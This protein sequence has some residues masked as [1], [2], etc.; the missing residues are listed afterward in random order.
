MLLPALPLKKRSPATTPFMQFRTILLTALLC[1]ATLALAEKK[2]GTPI[3]PLYLL[4]EPEK[5]LSIPQPDHP[6]QP[7][8][9]LRPVVIHTD[10]PQQ[11]IDV[12]HYQGRINWEIVA[13]NKDIR[14]VYVKATEGSGYVDDYYLRN[15][16]GAKQAGIPVGVYHFYRPTASVLTQLENFRD[17]VDPRQ[18]DLIPIV[19]VEKRGR[20]SLVHFQR[21]LLAFLEGV[22]RMF[23][24]KPIIY[25]GVNFYAKYLRGKF[26]QYRFMV[27]RYA[28]EFPGLCE[29]VPILIWQYSCTGEVD[30]IEGDVDRSVFLDRYS[31]ADIM[32]PPLKKGRK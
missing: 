27:A 30:G 8:A 31:V 28:E 23:G 9:E 24:V 32:L 17:N 16:Y 21:S 1:V 10:V 4:P 26:T 12:S 19:D 7:V 22:E 25:T 6:L 3:S 2:D 5:P 20:G 11:G 13:H 29:D 14:F 18:Q 15:L